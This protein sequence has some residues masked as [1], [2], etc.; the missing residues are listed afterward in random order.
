MFN[1]KIRYGH[2]RNHVLSGFSIVNFSR[3]WSYLFFP[4][5]HTACLFPTV[6]LQ[7]TSPRLP[8]RAS[9][10]KCVLFF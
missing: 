3:A 1:V 7:A 8:I 4:T 2:N 5:V 6:L 10:A 9:L